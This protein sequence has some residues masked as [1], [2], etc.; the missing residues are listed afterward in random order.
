MA[1]CD[2]VS[3]LEALLLE[4][5]VAILS[6]DVTQLTPACEALRLLLSP[7]KWQHCYIPLLPKELLGQVKRQQHALCSWTV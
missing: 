5:R 1:S 3:C 7:F 2:V 6:S 4:Q